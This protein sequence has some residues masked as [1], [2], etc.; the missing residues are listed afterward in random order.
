MRCQEN[1]NKLIFYQDTFIILTYLGTHLIC[2]VGMLLNK[3][4]IKIL[5]YLSE[6]NSSTVLSSIRLQSTS[7]DTFLTPA[8][9]SSTC[10]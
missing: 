5:C 1:V 8:M 4:L 2:Y 7:G 9:M 6:K 3:V 10:L